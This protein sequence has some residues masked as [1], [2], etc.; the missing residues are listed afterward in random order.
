[1]LDD[2]PADPMVGAVGAA[3]EALAGEHEV[4]VCRLAAGTG[5]EVDRYVTLLQQG[6]YG[7]AY[8]GIGLGLEES[9]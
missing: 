7:A 1:V 8:L 6:R 4:R 5:E 3:L 2:E 9:E